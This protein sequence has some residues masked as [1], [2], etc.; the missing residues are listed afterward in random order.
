MMPLSSSSQ[1]H[2]QPVAAWPVRSKK[3][4]V[5]T[6]THASVR[7]LIWLCSDQK[8]QMKMSRSSYIQS[9]LLAVVCCCGAGRLFSLD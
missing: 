9:E 2:G 7:N 6:Y 5:L 8:D 1:Q 4:P 3:S